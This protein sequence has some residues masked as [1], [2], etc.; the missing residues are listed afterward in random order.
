M[1]YLHPFCAAL[2][3]TLI[4]TRQSDSLIKRFVEMVAQYPDLLFNKKT[5]SRERAQ[6]FVHWHTQLLFGAEPT[7]RS[8]NN[9]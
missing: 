4:S 2:K 3:K 8:L 7:I 9:V 1:I 6:G 5:D